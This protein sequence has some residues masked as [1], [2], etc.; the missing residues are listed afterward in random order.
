MPLVTLRSAPSRPSAW[1]L[2][3]DWYVVPLMILS[4]VVLPEPLMPMSP[5]VPPGSTSTLTSF[6]TQR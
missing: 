2:P 6:S 1:H 5:S 3:A 4:R